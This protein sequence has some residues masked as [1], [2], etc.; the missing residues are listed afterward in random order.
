MLA[1]ASEAIAHIFERFLLLAGGSNSSPS[2]G[3]KG[4]QEVLYILD[5]LRDCLP[6][7]SL[8]SSTNILKYFKS[9]LELHQPLVTRRITDSLNVLCLHPTGEVSAEMLLDLLGSLAISISANE[10]SADSM[11]FAA[12]LLDVGMKKIYLLNRQICVA[13]IPVVFSALGGLILLLFFLIFFFFNYYFNFLSVDKY[14][15]IYLYKL[16][17][18]NWNLQSPSSNS[19]QSF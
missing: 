1:P 17:P 5:A 10:T 19:I 9:L 4:A 16:P 14:S 18:L 8:K 7:M 2:E 12:R 11:T 6:L 15:S 13:K 3:P